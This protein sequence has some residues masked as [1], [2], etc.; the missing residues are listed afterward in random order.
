MPLQSHLSS[1]RIHRGVKLPNLN[2]LQHYSG[3]DACL[4]VLCCCAKQSNSCL[5][6]CILQLS[7]LALHTGVKLPN[8]N[9]LQRYSGQDACLDVLYCYAKQSNSCL[10]PLR[11]TPIKTCFSHR[12]KTAEHQCT[13]ASHRWMSCVNAKSTGPSLLQQA[14][15]RQACHRAVNGANMLFADIR[16]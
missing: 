1:L 7:R 6:H 15:V 5:C 8:F 9:A 13:A 16:T 4:G 12:C 11:F 10:V 2:A 14:D 3:Q